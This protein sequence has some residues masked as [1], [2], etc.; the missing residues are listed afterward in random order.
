EEI[1]I[2]DNG[3]DEPR[4]GIEDL[5][6]G[7]VR[8]IGADHNH[9][10][11]WNFRRGFDQSSKKYFVILHDDDR[12]LPTF[13]ERAV[14]TLESDDGI[15]AVTTNGYIIDGK[16]RRN[17]QRLFPSE[18]PKTIELKDSKDV[19]IRTSKIFLPFPNTVYRNG[20]PQK[21]TIKEEFGKIWDGIF[22]ID[23]AEHGKIVILNEMLFE[24]RVHESQDSSII[25]EEFTERK[26]DYI[27]SKVE[28]YAEHPKIVSNIR[29]RQSKRFA[30][31]ALKVVLMKRDPKKLFDSIDRYEYKYVTAHHTI[32]Y[33]MLNPVIHFKEMLARR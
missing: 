21:I 24:Y 30:R 25:N 4:K 18:G 26:E 28:G 7:R 33:L 11:Q 14:A 16:G 22:L 27:L 20:F 9:P 17:G 19:A 32:Y 31:Y 1:V 5:I 3:S 15:V 29:H 2:L 10:H 12:V 23:L 8:W 6:G 13:L